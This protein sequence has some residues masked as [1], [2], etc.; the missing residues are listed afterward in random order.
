MSKQYFDQD[1]LTP[2]IWQYS[3]R[4]PDASF[5]IVGELV[6]LKSNPEHQLIVESINVF[7]NKVIVIAPNGSMIDFVPQ[8][9]LPYNLRGFVCAESIMIDH[10]EICLN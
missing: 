8:C 6:F 1:D 5:F 4:I 10:I 2:L 9:I 7:A 3:V